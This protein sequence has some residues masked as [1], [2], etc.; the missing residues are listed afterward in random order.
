MSLL[1]RSSRTLAFSTSLSGL[2]YERPATKLGVVI[3]ETTQTTRQSTRDTWVAAAGWAAAGWAGA[4]PPPP[5]PPVSP[6]VEPD[7][8]GPEW[9]VK[10]VAI[11]DC[12]GV[13]VTADILFGLSGMLTSLSGAN[14][15]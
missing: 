11:V 14:S 2:T 4:P 9:E 8:G 10:A 5:P 6:G 12:V 13:I 15:A 3:I 1:K 7:G